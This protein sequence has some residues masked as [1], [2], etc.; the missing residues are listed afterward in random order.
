MHPQPLLV[1]YP[2]ITPSLSLSFHS[3]LTHPKSPTPPST[4]LIPLFIVDF[5]LYCR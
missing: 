4:T 5:T 2:L 3:F 1:Y